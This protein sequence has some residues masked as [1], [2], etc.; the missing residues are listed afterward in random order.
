MFLV[1]QH[2]LC[3]GALG[4]LLEQTPTLPGPGPSSLL[5]AARV[6]CKG[7]ESDCRAGAGSVQALML[8]DAAALLTLPSLIR[9][10]LCP[11]LSS[12]VFPDTFSNM[13]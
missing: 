12:L 9:K 5:P 3:V 8:Q 1:V 2:L 11:C 13:L 10:N 7:H 6:E 4:M